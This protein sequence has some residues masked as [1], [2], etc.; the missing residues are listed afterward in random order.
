M[1]FN[2]QVLAYFEG[3]LMPMCSDKK[4]IKDCRRPLKGIMGECLVFY[5]ESVIVYYMEL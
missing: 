4:K 1:G 5:I 3:L 2:Y